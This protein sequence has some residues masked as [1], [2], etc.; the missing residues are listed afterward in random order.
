MVQEQGGVDHPILLAQPPCP[1]EDIP[2]ILS[3][4]ELSE[5]TCSF[6]RVASAARD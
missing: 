3:L 4:P 1:L 2:S 5:T 6:L